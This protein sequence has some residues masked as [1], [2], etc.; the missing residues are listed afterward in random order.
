VGFAHLPH[1]E[2]ALGRAPQAGGQPPG[3]DQ[4]EFTCECGREF[5]YV[6]EIA[7]P[8]AAWCS[9]LVKEGLRC[10]GNWVSDGAK[11]RGDFW[12]NRR[13]TLS[14]DG[15]RL[16][17]LRGFR[18]RPP[19]AVCQGDAARQRNDLAIGRASQEPFRWMQIG[20]PPSTASRPLQVSKEPR[21]TACVWRSRDARR[22]PA[23]DA[24]NQGN[25]T[26]L[27]L[28]REVG[29][30]RFPARLLHPHQERVRRGFKRGEW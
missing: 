5:S 27:L 24:R 11:E 22:L 10:S 15:R 8:R 17:P 26:R 14:R 13:S 4:E 9:R 28:P 6:V 20:G 25:G 19:A 29:H 2:G 23:T 12:R 3:A 18:A 21:D 1:I 16:A 30:V 7:N